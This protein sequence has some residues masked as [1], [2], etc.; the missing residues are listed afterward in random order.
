M[1]AVQDNTNND[2]KD[3]AFSQHI[4][5]ARFVRIIRIVP[6]C[7]G[8]QMLRIGEGKGRVR[9]YRCKVCAAT[10]SGVTTREN[11]Y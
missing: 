7:H 11:V 4:N 2:A 9:Y 1:I 10:A 5:V 8:H 6:V 3:D